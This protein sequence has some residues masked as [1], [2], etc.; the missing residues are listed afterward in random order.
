MLALRGLETRDRTPGLTVDVDGTSGVVAG[1]DGVEGDDTII[2][3]E[4][5]ATEGGVAGSVGVVGVTVT[6]GA[7]TTVD[8][9]R[10]WLA[11]VKPPLGELCVCRM[12][13]YVRWSCSTRPRGR[14]WQGARRC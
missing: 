5:D 9:L 3:G 2:I 10:A 11:F 6:T 1:H 7:D 14:R 13:K 4:V 8:T 12:L